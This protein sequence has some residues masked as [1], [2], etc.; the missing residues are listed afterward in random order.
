MKKPASFPL[1]YRFM[2]IS[3]LMLILLLGT[4]ALVLGSLQTRTIQGRIEK[5][6]LDIARNLAAVSRDYFITYNYVALEKLANQVVD[7][8]DILYVVFYDKEGRIAGYSQRPDLQNRILTDE[9]SRKAVAATVPL[10]VIHDQNDAGRPVLHVAFPVI[11]SDS[12]ARWGTIRVCL[13]LGLMHQQIR[14]T[15]WT[16]GVLGVIALGAGLLISNWTAQRVTRPL[17]KLAAD[18]VDAAR[19]DLTLKV[20]VNTRDEVEILA[21][22][23]SFL[24]QEIL[25]QKKTTRGTASGNPAVAA[26]HRKSAGHHGGRAAGHRHER[27]GHHG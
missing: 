19:G 27:K 23:F 18:T 13:S 25:A 7:I 9:I 5:Q 11:L 26:I 1:R 15:R 4:L 2:L 21:A 17:E 24:I 10:V 3:S 12:Q 20:A 8:S 22:N 14:Q 6:G 16:I